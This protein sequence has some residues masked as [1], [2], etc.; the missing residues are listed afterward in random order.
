[1]REGPASRSYGLQVARLA[2]VPR[3]VVAA[4]RSYLGVLERRAGPLAPPGPQAELS[5]APPAAPASDPG[6]ESAARLAAEIEAL[7]PDA[8]T[9]R[10]ALEALYRLK[11]LAR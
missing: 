8:L 6:A 10:E 9:P 5:F 3:E 11:D 2:G 4:A 1:V 7:D